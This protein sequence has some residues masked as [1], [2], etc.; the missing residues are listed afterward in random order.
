MARVFTD[1][2]DPSFIAEGAYGELPASSSL[3]QGPVTPQAEAFVA[4]DIPSTVTGEVADAGT[5]YMITER[6]LAAA[7]TEAVK[8][9]GKSLM[10]PEEEY[11]G[12][13]SSGEIIEAQNAYA[14]QAGTSIAQMPQVGFGVPQIQYDAL[15]R[16]S[17]NYLRRMGVA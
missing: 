15:Y 14:V 5:D 17:S 9:V 3:L 2:T 1:P 11:Y 7:G 8:E 4:P 16:P 10:A 12:Y 6:S 13:G